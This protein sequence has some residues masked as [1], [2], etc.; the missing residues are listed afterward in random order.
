M[1]NNN[2]NYFIIIIIKFFNYLACQNNLYHL[3]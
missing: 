1:E 2:N 3:L